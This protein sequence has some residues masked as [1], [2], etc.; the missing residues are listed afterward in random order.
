M[1]TRKRA[2]TNT[3]Q[4]HRKLYAE[5]ECIQAC[6][7]ALSYERPMSLEAQQ[8]VDTLLGQ[9]ISLSSLSRWLKIY[10]D[11]VKAA[12]NDLAL[13]PTKKEL[14]AI[15]E[16]THNL[17]VAKLQALA[18]KLLD[19]ASDDKKIAGAT[20]QQLGV[21]YGIAFDKL[22]LIAGLSPE[23]EQALKELDASCR[24]AGMDTVEAIKDYAQAIGSRAKHTSE[25]MIE[26]IKDDTK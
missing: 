6:T 11:R 4:S 23:L 10:G 19:A 15:V 26:V 14:P 20:L 7:V 22:R 13:Q 25:P 12:K 16:E 5:S 8:A 18:N 3:T 21:V 2:Q 24:Q 17:Q 9:H 1:T